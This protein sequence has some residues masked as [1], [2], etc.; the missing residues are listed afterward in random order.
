MTRNKE[1][2]NYNNIFKVAKYYESLIEYKFI[3]ILQINHTFEHSALKG[4]YIAM[5]QF[6]RLILTCLLIKMVFRLL[7]IL[8]IN[9][10]TFDFSRFELQTL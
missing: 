7:M 10:S 1:H 6:G 9:F 3:K 4:V 2:K 8:L 5:I